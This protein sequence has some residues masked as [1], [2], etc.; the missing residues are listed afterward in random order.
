MEL[1]KT[2]VFVETGEAIDADGADDI[3]LFLAAGL[4][5]KTDMVGVDVFDC[6]AVAVCCG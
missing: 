3:E 5:F 6:T 4:I 2:A 1:S